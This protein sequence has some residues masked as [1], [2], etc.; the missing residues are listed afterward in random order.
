MAKMTLNSSK[1]KKTLGNAQAA[2][3]SQWKARA[4]RTELGDDWQLRQKSAWKACP[5]A[6]LPGSTRKQRGEWRN[7]PMGSVFTAW[8]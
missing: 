3:S 7:Y 5:A 1:K 6:E 2:I 4:E 8:A